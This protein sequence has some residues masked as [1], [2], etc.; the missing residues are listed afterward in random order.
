MFQKVR[1]EALIVHSRS[2]KLT[3]LD[4]L[5]GA[6][7]ALN[8]ASQTQIPPGIFDLSVCSDLDDFAWNDGPANGLTREQDA[9]LQGELPDNK[10]IGPSQSSGQQL[11]S[12]YDV[13]DYDHTFMDWQ[14]GSYDGTF[15]PDLFSPSWN[16]AGNLFFA[17]ATQPASDWGF[18]NSSKC[19]NGRA[20]LGRH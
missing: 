18:T 20:M 12:H 11:E 19:I 8:T 16:D 1:C 4:A 7:Q 2:S 5:K 17:E 3:A 13:L 9:S 14:S 15:G 10:W 6:Y